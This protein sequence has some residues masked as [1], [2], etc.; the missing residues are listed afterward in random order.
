MRSLMAEG[1]ASYY[2]GARLIVESAGTVSVSVDPYC[3]WAMNEVGIDISLQS[4]EMLQDKDL[5]LYDRII[6]MGGGL[7]SLSSKPTVERWEIPDPA[8]VRSGPQE[9]IKSFRAVR[10]QIETRVKRLLVELL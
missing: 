10:N 2:G 6:A 3:Q 4:P 7:P 1:F 9:M 8:S 5:S